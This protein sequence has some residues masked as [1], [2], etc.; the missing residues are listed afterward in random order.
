[1]EKYSRNNDQSPRNWTYGGPLPDLGKGGQGRRMDCE[2]AVVRNSLDHENPSIGA[3]KSS[4]NRARIAD[5]VARIAIVIGQQLGLAR[6]QRHA[7]TLDHRRVEVCL[8]QTRACAPDVEI[9]IATGL[10]QQEDGDQETD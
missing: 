3:A 7:F 4:A 1:V 2:L 8:E 5:V 10:K 6:T 9:S